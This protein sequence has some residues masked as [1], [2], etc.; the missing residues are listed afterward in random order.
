MR[1]HSD[2]Q[3]I[4]N[5]GVALYV[6]TAFLFFSG[7]CTTDPYTGEQKISKTAIGAVIGVGVGAA[8][9]ADVGLF[10]LL[11]LVEDV[12]L[13]PLHPRVSVWKLSSISC[14]ASSGTSIRNIGLWRSVRRAPLP[15]APERARGAS[16]RI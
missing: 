12:I 10:V 8:I 14:R 2:D 13:A 1:I 3:L 16:G 4:R 6:A 9:G 7:A 11:G 5:K 15:C